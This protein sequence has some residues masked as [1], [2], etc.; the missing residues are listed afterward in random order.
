Q[1]FFQTGKNGNFSAVA[2]VP[3]DYFSATGQL[4]GN[5]LYNWKNLKKDGYSWWISRIKKMLSLVDY[6][7]IDHFRGFES[8]WAVPF[9][10]ENAVNGKWEKGPGIDLFNAIRSELGDLP[11]I[12]EDLGIIT[13]EV[14]SLRDESGLPGMKVLQFAFDKNEWKAGSLKNAFLPH[15]FE[16][17]N[18][19]IYT[20]THDND[21]TQ[22][23][24]ESLDD[25]T[26][27]LIAEYFTGEVQTAESA[28][29]LVKSKKLTKEFI[30]AA[31]SSTANIA[32]IPL[33]D[34]YALSSET[35]MNMPSTSGANWAWRA[36]ECMIKGEKAEK[37]AVWLH[38]LCVLY[39]R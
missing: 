20:G 9:G 5:P 29:K 21:T 19:V 39:A 23:L 4:W 11:L 35:R 12:A 30:K 6:V 15:N 25:E 18:C 17:T 26:V 36:D 1:K 8:Y 38:E 16:T 10:S 33:Q 37:M 24:L 22:G 32:V 31:L 28:K 2:G 34:L 14:R 13:D 7:R 27:R 3:P